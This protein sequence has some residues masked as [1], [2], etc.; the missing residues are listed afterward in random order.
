MYTPKAELKAGLLVLAAAGALLLFIYRAAGSQLPWA[1]EGPK[2]RL[3]FAQG[4]TAPNPG[5]AV[6]MNGMKVG[7]VTSIRQQEE[8]RGA[9]GPDGK[10]IPLTDQDRA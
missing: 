8:I 7:R 10:T 6:R 2:L 1:K 4:F 5:D 9:P 3:R